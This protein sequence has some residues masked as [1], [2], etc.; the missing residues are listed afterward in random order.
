MIAALRSL[1]HPN[2]RLQITGQ[3][4]SLI[5]T[6][7]QRVA[8][9]WL[10]Y[11]ISGS[12]L[13]LGLITF[14][15]LFP[16]LV[17]SPFAGSFADRHN[18]YRTLM[19]TQTGLMIQ[20]G[21]L[22]LL[23]WFKVYNL[24]Y[25]GVLALMQGIISVFDVTSRQSLLKELVPVK[26]DLPNAIALNSS[27]FNGARMI[28]PAVAGV[29]LSAYGEAVCFTVNFVSFIA[30]LLTLYLMKLDLRPMVGSKENWKEALVEGYHYLRRSPHIA[31]LILLL[32][33]SSLLVMPYFNTLLPVVAKE[34]FHGDAKTF[35]WFE[36]AAGMGAMFG[37]VYMAFQKAGRNL[38]FLVIGASAL[39][40]SSIFL[41]STI[42]HLWSA[43]GFTMLAAT[44]MMVQNS[45]I[46]TYIQTHSPAALR[47]RAIS[48]YVMAFQGVLPLGS[49]LAGF[50]A[51]QMTIHY[52]LI[53]HGVAGLLIS[54]SFALYIRHRIHDHPEI[55]PR[56]IAPAPT[57]DTSTSA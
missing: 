32:T 50:M 55:L 39:L 49:L 21:L 35:S 14:A 53:V 19:I 18:K 26:E 5:G 25:I 24:W 8:V 30:V 4:I 11:R 46:N 44:G 51:R 36:S 48:Y 47:G 56:V 37:A 2:Y 40:S 43:L 57:I 16:T 10:V 42:H 45:S 33:A 12:A 22:A 6:W 9:S 52:A 41:V 7:M 20:A 23:V 34:I 13:I 31:S 38:R 15:Q 17:I 29:V 54:L 1:R 28:G 3:A 27:V